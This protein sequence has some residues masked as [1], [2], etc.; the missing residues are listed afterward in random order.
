MDELVN[1]TGPSKRF[2]V[3][4]APKVDLVIQVSTYLAYNF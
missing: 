1:N 2:T 4:L 3:F